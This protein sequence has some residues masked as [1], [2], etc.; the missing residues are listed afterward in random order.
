MSNTIQ[1][2]GF[3][4]DN[5]SYW[6]EKSQTFA[7][8]NSSSCKKEKNNNKKLTIAL[9]ALGVA[10]AAGVAIA[11]KKRA[12]NLKNINFQKGKAFLKG[13]TEG[14]T[15]LIK[16]KLA[17]GDKIV[18]E[19][20]DGILQK[21][22]RVGAVNFEKVYTR[23]NGDLFVK[24]I[25]AKGTREVN[26]SAIQKN[27]KKSQDEISELIKNKDK[28]SYEEFKQKIPNIKYKN[29]KQTEALD[30]ILV[31][32]YNDKLKQIKYERTNKNLKDIQFNKGYAFFNGK[33]YSG[34]IYANMPNGDKVVIETD[35]SGKIVKS[36]RSGEKNFTK[37]Y[38]NAPLQT[39][40]I[41]ENGQSKEINLYEKTENVKKEVLLKQNKALEEKLKKEISAKADEFALSIKNAS[42]EE[43]EKIET[44]VSNE[45]NELI[46]RGSARYKK[47]FGTEPSSEYYSLKR[48]TPEEK[49]QYELIQAKRGKIYN[50]KK[51]RENQ[52]LKDTVYRS[53]DKPVKTANVSEYWNDAE[54]VSLNRYYDDIAYNHEIR[55][56]RGDAELM[57]NIDSLFEKAP[58]LE[59]DAVVYRGVCALKKGDKPFI[60]S[61]KEGGII[62]HNAYTSTSTNCLDEQFKHFVSDPM[63][64]NGVVMRIRLPKGTK[65]ILGGHNE[66]L[67]PRNSEIK[68]LKLDTIGGVKVAEC[69]YVLPKTK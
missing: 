63:A 62:Y 53:G 5:A 26:I 46:K 37:E 22:T 52:L 12:P 61:I 23:K 66:Y 47:E 56:N 18:L 1:P 4:Q 15:G 14:Y 42:K 54:S 64:G 21:S 13:K 67:L 55:Q 40:K 17:S 27:V 33:E 45:A 58:A 31:Q 60:D 25:G 50:E 19:Y 49:R 9:A 68:V 20:K 48:L 41:T 16:D 51:C 57:K 10:A 44:S 43:L 34:K 11:L 35:W 3:S 6:K 7:N 59:E 36:S 69:E 32:K 38:Y 28:I 24:S 2:S 65:G 30:D 39:V 29:K 8:N